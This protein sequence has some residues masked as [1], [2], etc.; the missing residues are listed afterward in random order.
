MPG[1]DGSRLSPAGF[2]PRLQPELPGGTT[3]LSSG[4]LGIE[5][6]RRFLVLPSGPSHSG[7]V[8][9]MSQDLPS[10]GWQR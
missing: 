10:C 9:A 4:A 3:P 6:G 5:D 1:A 8:M 7:A 2:P